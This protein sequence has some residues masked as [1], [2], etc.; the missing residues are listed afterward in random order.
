MRLTF[1][2]VRAEAKELGFQLSK[3]GRAY[4]LTD[5]CSTC[6]LHSLAGVEWQLDFYC[7]A[8][9][10]QMRLNTNALTTALCGNQYFTNNRVDGPKGWAIPSK[11][12]AAEWFDKR[13]EVHWE[14]STAAASRRRS[15]PRNAEERK[16]INHTRCNDCRFNVIKGGE[17]YMRHPKLWEKKL[18]LGWNDNLCIGCLE[19]RLGRKVRLRDMLFLP[20][21]SW[22]FPQSDRLTNR[23]GPRID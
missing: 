20:A 16:S 14:A 7:G 9:P 13:G 17:Y 1:K 11:P 8:R 22:M 10:L 4:K 2:S 12:G 21:Y 3:H 18:K 23:I 19:Q 6:Y 5:G 15:K